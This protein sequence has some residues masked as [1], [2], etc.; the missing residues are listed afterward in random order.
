MHVPPTDTHRTHRFRSNAFL[1]RWALVNPRALRYYR[2]LLRW[3]HAPPDALAAWNWSRRRQ[4]IRFAAAH[5]PY[6]RRLFHAH[7]IRPD[8]IVRPED[9]FRIPL[10]TKDD[11]RTYADALVA[12]T[13]RPRHLVRCA[14]GGSTGDPLTVYHDARVPDQAMGWRM[15]SWWGVSPWDDAA[16]VWRAFP[17]TLLH[18]IARRAFWWPTKRLFLDASSFTPTD[19]E[20]FFAAWNRVRPR[21]LQGYTGALCHLATLIRDRK[22]AVHA[23]A[24]VW[25]TSSPMSLP[26]RRFLE[27]A[28]HAPAYSQYGCGEVYWIAAEC[29]A[30]SGLHIFTDTRH[31]EVVDDHGMPLP[32]GSLGRIAVTDLEN[33]AFPLI[34]YVN[35]DLGR[36]RDDQCPCGVTL[37][38]MDPVRGRETDSILLPD[39][40]CVGG[41]YLT[42]IFDA[43]PDAV[44]AF[45]VRVRADGALAVLAVPNGTAAGVRPV[46]DRVRATLVEKTRGQVLVTVEPVAT[47]PHDRGK[48]RY[49]FREDVAENLRA[50][51]R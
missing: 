35:G 10:L 5:V 38:L 4:L 36:L 45:Q 29:R 3:Q 18:R 43:F 8:D 30:R 44:Q 39:G 25:T 20:R 37:P 7:G 28:F 13:A 41:D 17:R 2:D 6:Y 34:R 40:T 15:L 12:T 14:T 23:P 22:T 51:R 48:L 24:A 33:A 32:N 11:V 27:D 16:F 31:I 9:F 42:T 19:A 50:A 47:I 49:V 21:L 46:F 26:Q 1:V